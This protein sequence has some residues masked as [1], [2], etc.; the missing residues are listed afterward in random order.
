VLS[1]WSVDATERRLHDAVVGFFEF[2]RPRLAPF[3]DSRAALVEFREMGL[4]IG[5]LTDAPYGM[6]RFLVERD[7]ADGGIADC[8]DVLLTSVD[9]GWRKPE[10]H[11]FVRLAEMLGVG[12]GEVLCVGNEGKDVAGAKAAEMF[13]V[14]LDRDGGGARHG[15]D[16]TVRSLTEVRDLVYTG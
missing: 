12:R 1:A 15:Q 5:V 9:V 2:F 3:D 10:P 14:L 4:R 8:V 6:P 7:L 16:A 13:A 11:G